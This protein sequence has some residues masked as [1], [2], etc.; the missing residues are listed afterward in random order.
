MKAV[1]QFWDKKPLKLHFAQS[2]DSD[3]SRP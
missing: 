2:Q 1:F 3:F